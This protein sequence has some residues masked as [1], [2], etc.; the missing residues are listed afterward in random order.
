MPLD[1]LDE[2]RRKYGT[3]EPSAV[4]LDVA[5]ERAFVVEAKGRTVITTP[6]RE[7]AMNNDTFTYISGRFVQADAA[8]A[9]GA[10]WTSE[11]LQLGAGTVAGGPLNWL[12]DE[13]T[14]IG[15]L[16]D[17]TFVS[18]EA[19]AAGDVGNH[20]TS[21]AAI[22]RFL[23]PEKARVIAEAAGDG[24]AFYSMEC[25]SRAVM[26][27]D[28]PGRPGCGETF[29][30]GDY[31]AGR[32]C[33]HMRERSSVRRFVD[34]IFQ[35]GAAIVPPIRPGWSKANVDIVRQAA[36]ATEKAGFDPEG[37]DGAQAVD[38]AAAILQWANRDEAQPVR[39]QQ[40]AIV[41]PGGFSTTT[42]PV[43]F[44]TNGTTSS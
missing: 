17:G 36:A 8:N 14:I 23:H 7:V 24:R 44:T 43:Y 18:R 40:P 5:P 4:P 10:Y 35:G 13:N 6:V 37:L 26:C 21:T 3:P 16:L 12:H 34:P 2:M 22:W 25:I 1:L 33:S 41:T 11:D 32:V 30:Y 39:R 27:L 42:T 28:T 15:S 31:D 20:I 9:N 19:A 38:L 29:G